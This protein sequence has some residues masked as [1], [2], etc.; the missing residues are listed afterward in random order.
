MP[1]VESVLVPRKADRAAAILL[2]ELFSCARRPQGGGRLTGAHASF[3]LV[4]CWFGYPLVS[5]PRFRSCRLRV[6]PIRSDA[7]AC[8]S[9]SGRSR[10]FSAGLS[11]SG[12]RL[13][14]SAFVVMLQ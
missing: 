12:E 4:R 11:V 10:A 13:N 14:G 3:S 7:A 5:I 1:L 2:E 9:S 6:E 8:P